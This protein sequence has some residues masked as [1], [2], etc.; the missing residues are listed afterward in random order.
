MRTL[1][2]DL[3]TRRVGLAMSD[4]G[5]GFAT[6]VEVLQVNSPDQATAPILQLIGKE[7]VRRLL[8]GL[9][10]NMDDSFGPQAWAAV[11]WGQELSRRSGLPVVFID[12]RLSSFSAEQG[13]IERKRGGEK[14]SRKQKKER[15]DAIVAAALLQAFL[16]GKA[17]PVEIP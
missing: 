5:G 17:S 1:A 12:E 15:L 14:I 13:L 16:D 11:R 4:E 6:P 3:G 2:I 10:L 9:P 7:D 8:V